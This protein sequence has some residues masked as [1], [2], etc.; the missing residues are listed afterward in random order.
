M[1]PASR[2]FS[3]NQD[4][5]MFP[6]QQSA[7]P[8]GEKSQAF[9]WLSDLLSSS[10]PVGIR[11]PNLLIRSQTLYP[12]ELRAHPFLFT[13]VAVRSVYGFFSRSQA[14]FS[15]SSKKNEIGAPDTRP[16]G[17]AAHRRYTYRAPVKAALPAGEQ[18]HMMPPDLSVCQSNRSARRTKKGGS[19]NR[20][21]R[22]GV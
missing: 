3:R 16:A 7:A 15:F 11:T 8:G 18:G 6:R 1:Q 12:I 9:T 19:Q 13:A 14:F 22:S 10:T 5:P 20:R 2:M 21:S 17:R 4:A